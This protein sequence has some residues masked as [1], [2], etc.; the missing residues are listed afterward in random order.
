MVKIICGPVKSWR[1][2]GREGGREGR[3]EGGKEGRREGGKEGWPVNEESLIV[4]IMWRERR[5]KEEIWKGKESVG[6]LGAKG[7]FEVS[8][9]PPCPPPSLPPF[10][11]P[12]LPPSIPAT[13]PSSLRRGGTGG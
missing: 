10:L 4:R 8:F 3:R 1:E 5:R 11:P 9:R 12:S 6:C 2:G 7:D 13:S